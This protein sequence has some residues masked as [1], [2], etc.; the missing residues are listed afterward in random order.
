MRLVI[1]H[2]IF[3][4]HARLWE[5]S[6]LLG[7]V[8]AQVLSQA[9][10]MFEVKKT[11]SDPFETSEGLPTDW[12]WVQTVQRKRAGM[13][14]CNIGNL[15]LVQLCP[16]EYPTPH[17]NDASVTLVLLIQVTSTYLTLCLEM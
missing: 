5:S 6:W 8:G 7:E 9:V 13:G 14:S 10:H 16:A 17:R 3:H 4:Q 1:P 2:V 12:V 11:D 15:E